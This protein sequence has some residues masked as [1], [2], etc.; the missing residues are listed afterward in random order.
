M[1]NRAA[2]RPPEWTAANLADLPRAVALARGDRDVLRD[3]RSAATVAL[4]SDDLHPA[5]P[6]AHPVSAAALATDPKS[7]RVAVGE[8]KAW[9]KCQVLV[10]DAAGNRVVHRLAYPTVAAGINQDGTR[11]LA[12][13]PDGRWL[14]AGTRSARVVRFDLNE[15]EKAPV[16]QK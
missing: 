10:V 16:E 2:A 5:D 3:L 9:G 12:F 11:A 1:R 6:V 4:V 7:G 13:S 8:Y 15:P 14:F